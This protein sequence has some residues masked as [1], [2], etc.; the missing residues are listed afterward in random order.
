ME[1]TINKS[2]NIV[3]FGDLKIGDKF[4]DDLWNLPNAEYLLAIKDSENSCIECKTGVRHLMP[5][6]D[7]EVLHG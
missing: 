5:S 4:E 3:K 7:Y 1:K 6:G 2:D